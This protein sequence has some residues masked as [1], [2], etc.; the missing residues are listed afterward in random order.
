MVFEM[1]EI[2][3]KF[4]HSVKEPIYLQLYRYF[5]TEIQAGRI[6]AGSQLPSIRRCAEHLKI[7]RNTVETAYQQLLA[8]GY[9]ESKP[10]KGLFVTEIEKDLNKPMDVSTYSNSQQISQSTKTIR[11]DFRHGNVD[12]S[13][14]PFSVWRKLTNDC[15]QPDKMDLFLYGDPQGDP[16]LRNEIARYL[17][18]SRGV[19][20][21]PDQIVVGA[22]IQQLLAL[23]CLLLGLKNQTVAVEDPGYNGAKAIFRRYGFNIQPIPLEEDG[24]SI[25]NLRES[26]A[27]LVYVTPSHQ[28]PCGMVMPISKR[29]KLLRWAE[30]TDGLII[31]DDYDGEFRYHGKP[32]PALQGLDSKGRVAYMGT[33]SKS[34]LPSLRLGYMVLPMTLLNEFRQNFRVFEHTVSRIHQYTLQLFMEKGFWER[35]IRKMRHMYQRKHTALLTAISEFMGND[36]RVIGKDSGLHVLLEINN[37]MTEKELIAAAE[38]VGVKVYPTSHNWLKP[39]QKQR[40]MILLGFGGLKEQEIV[41]GIQLLSCAWFS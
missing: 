1:F 27:D 28:F 15:F 4:D 37:E 11:Y 22:G 33:F 34:L 35:H 38:R 5:T 12:L 31:E 39:L 25:E 19:I 32:I 3:P 17:H 26:N 29:M 23:L 14:F 20:C 18:Q 7:A 6:P 41:D 21:S 24:I 8:E 10:R 40:P 30:E 2:T 9:V 36:V 13:G 16:G